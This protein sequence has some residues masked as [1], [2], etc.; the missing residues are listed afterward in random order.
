MSRLRI[1]A[2]CGAG[3]LASVA[4]HAQDQSQVQADSS[5]VRLAPLEYVGGVPPVMDNPVITHVFFDQLEGRWS[6]SNPLFRYDGQAWSGTDYNKLWLKSEGFVDRGQFVDGQHEVLY[7]R[8]ITTFFDLQGGVRVDLDSARTRTWAA[9]GVQ[10]LAVYFFDLEATAYASDGGHFAGRLRGFYDFLIT[11]HLFLQPEAELDFYSKADPAAG[12]GS[13]LSQI[14][15]G[16]RLIYEITRKFAPYV[17]VAYNGNFGQT[18]QF[19]RFELANPA[20][21]SFVFGL[22]SW[23]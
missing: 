23:F 14:D 11:N 15:T 6:G 2:L 9:L 8:A 22:R 21:I 5:E 4:A 10:G 7:D 12:V 18:R 13:G 20:G 3:L 17:G 19:Q 1:A 16:L